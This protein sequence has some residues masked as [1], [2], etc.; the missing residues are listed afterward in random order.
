M[1]C[2]FEGVE[3]T[4][5]EDGVVGIGHVYHIESYVLN[6]SICQCAERHRQRYG[7]NWFNILSTKTIYKKEVSLMSASVKVIWT[8]DHFVLIMGPLTAT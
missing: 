3:Q 1:K 6:A 7:S 2:C 8:S 5:C 4:S